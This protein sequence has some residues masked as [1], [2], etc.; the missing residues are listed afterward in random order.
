MRLIFDSL[1]RAEILGDDDNF[2]P[3]A[4]RLVRRAPSSLIETMKQLALADRRGDSAAL[5]HLHDLIQ[6]NPLEAA[7]TIISLVSPRRD[8]IYPAKM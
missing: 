4:P 7:K 6:E 2:K 1:G 5:S 8:E 3:P